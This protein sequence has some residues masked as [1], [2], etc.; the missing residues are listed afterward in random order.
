MVVLTLRFCGGELQIHAFAFFVDQLDLSQ[1]LSIGFNTAVFRSSPAII[2]Y[3]FFKSSVLS[4]GAVNSFT[5]YVRVYFKMFPLTYTILCFILY[6]TIH[7][8]NTLKANK[9]R[10]PLHQFNNL[11]LSPDNPPNPST[12]RF[13]PHSSCGIIPP[14][15]FTANLVFTPRE[16]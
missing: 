13:A 14:H 15:S 16:V 2:R 5:S 11:Y 6:L 12:I 9:R 3:S 8:G 4:T 7:Q 1:C 10:S